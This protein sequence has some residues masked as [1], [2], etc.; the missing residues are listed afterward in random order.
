[1][2]LF[3]C[4]CASQRDILPDADS[5]AFENVWQSVLQFKLL[6]VYLKLGI[7]NLEHEVDSV[8]LEV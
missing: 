3:S 7:E 8:F 1:M 6:S 4:Y 5:P 2:F